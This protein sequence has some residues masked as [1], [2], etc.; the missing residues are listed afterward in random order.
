M[1][2]TAPQLDQATLGL[3]PIAPN[4]TLDVRAI[5]GRPIKT[6]VTPIPEMRGVIALH[7]EPVPEAPSLG[8]LRGRNADQ[9]G[10]RPERAKN[11][12]HRVPPFCDSMGGNDAMG[13]NNSV[14]TNQT[15]FLI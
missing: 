14:K 13:S 3:V 5:P 15:N 4:P 12:L 7:R 6:G 2:P 9:Q 8:R 1:L 10:N 11:E